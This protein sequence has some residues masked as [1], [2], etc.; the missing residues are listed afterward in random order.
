MT[1]RS[2]RGCCCCVGGLGA[3]THVGL[4]VKAKRIIRRMETLDTILES[5]RR[6]KT[7][8]CDFSKFSEDVKK[9]RQRQGEI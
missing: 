7:S 6:I 8:F 3:N 4:I 5:A 2:T 1:L 9:E